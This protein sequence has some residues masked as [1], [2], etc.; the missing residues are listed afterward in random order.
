MQLDLDMQMHI[1]RVCV[2]RTQYRSKT[3]MWVGGWQV[4]V[5]VEND[6]SVQTELSILGTVAQELYNDSQMLKSFQIVDW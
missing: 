2:Y 4:G 3:L 5:V 6:S 1:F